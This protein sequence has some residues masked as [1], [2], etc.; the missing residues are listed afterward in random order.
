MVECDIIIYDI[1]EDP[2]QIDEAVW[3]V[4]GKTSILDVVCRSCVDPC[5]LLS[6]PEQMNEVPVLLLLS[7]P[8]R[9]VLPLPR[10][11][12]HQGAGSR[13]G[14]PLSTIHHSRA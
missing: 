7:C 3:A 8:S 12:A 10:S 9:N 2:E 13:G 4:S 14:G 6:D 11:K 5:S 1:T